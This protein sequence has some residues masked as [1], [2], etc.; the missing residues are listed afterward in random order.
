MHAHRPARMRTCKSS[1]RAIAG[2]SAPAGRASNRAHIVRYPATVVL[3]FASLGTAPLVVHAQGAG[4]EWVILN[5]EVED[6]YLAGEYDRAEVVAQ[7]ALRVAER[8]VGSDHP[9]V[10]ASLEKLVD[11]YRATD[12][13]SEAEALEKRA[14]AI[15]AMQR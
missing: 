15:R 12:R 6:R 5:R 11:L 4:I 3:A 9:E 7:K 8:N 13:K 1:Q 10:A 14:A 2:A